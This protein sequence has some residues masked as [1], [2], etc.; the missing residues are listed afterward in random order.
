MKTYHEYHFRKR[1]AQIMQLRKLAHYY[2]GV[3]FESILPPV[4]SVDKLDESGSHS[5][6]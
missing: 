4:R 6:S 5:I 2:Y 1:G 3:D